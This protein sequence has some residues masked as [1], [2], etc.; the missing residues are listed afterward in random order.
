[1]TDYMCGRFKLLRIY[2]P[3]E[4]NRS[5]SYDFHGLGNIQNY[6]PTVGSGNNK[7]CNTNL[8][9]I[10]AGCLWLFEQNIINNT[11]SLSKEQIEIII[12]YIMTWLSYKLNQNSPEKFLKFKDFYTN[13]IE[14]NTDYNNCKKKIKNNNYEDCSNKLKEKM[15]Y[16]NFKEFIEAKKCLMDIDIKDMSK[17]YEALKLLCIMY[18]EYNADK[19]NCTKCLGDANN[20]VVKYDQLNKDHSITKD[21]LYNKLFS[22]LSTDYNS[23]KDICNDTSTFP[24][25]N[26]TQVSVTNSVDNTVQGFEATSSNPS[27]I[28]KLIPVLSILVAIAIFLG[29]S[30]KVINKEIKKLFSLY[31]SKR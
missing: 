9:K 3:D 29:I 2:F 4:L 27:I 19:S 23:L 16:K 11:D 25:I 8:D 31:I 21:G 22:T 7:K 26:T 1:M 20:F 30:Y 14:N 18:T 5:T 10:K 12:T 6:C 28:S 17:F 15:G 13:H 24:P